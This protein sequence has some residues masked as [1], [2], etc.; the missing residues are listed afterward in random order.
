MRVALLEKI[1][2]WHA[3]EGEEIQT[4]KSF[5]FHDWESIFFKKTLNIEVHIEIKQGGHSIT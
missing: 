1:A 5:G 4:A 2:G 3:H